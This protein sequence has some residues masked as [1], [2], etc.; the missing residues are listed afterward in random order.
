MNSV[1]LNFVVYI[2][3][4]EL[5]SNFID[6]S[7]SGGMCKGPI[8]LQPIQV[9]RLDE[10]HVRFGSSR[11]RAKLVSVAGGF[12]SRRHPRGDFGQLRFALRLA[13]WMEAMLIR[14]PH[15][16]SAQNCANSPQPQQGRNRVPTAI[17]SLHLPW[18]SNE[19]W[20][21][22]SNHSHGSQGPLLRC[23]P[24]AHPQGSPPSQPLELWIPVKGFFN[25][26]VH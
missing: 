15:V 13:H 17:L 4:D 10:F 9:R 20:Q 11:Q 19:R 1:R 21:D 5:W 3:D 12:I 8:H 7:R 24:Q 2:A 25:T 14:V 23:A 16:P 26:F 22:C 6:K 18:V